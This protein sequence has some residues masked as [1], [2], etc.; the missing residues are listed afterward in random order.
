MIFAS[1]SILA[2]VGLSFPSC[3]EKGGRENLFWRRGDKGEAQARSLRYACA[4]FRS[5][6]HGASQ[7]GSQNNALN[8]TLGLK[9]SF[10]ERRENYSPYLYT[11]D[12]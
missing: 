10:F 12:E 11:Y 4:F 6:R 5:L 3:A 2:Y 7:C 9:N 1:F 8:P